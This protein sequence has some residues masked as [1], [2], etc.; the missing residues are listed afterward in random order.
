MAN[1]S[2]QELSAALCH[3]DKR[4]IELLL[5]RAE[6]VQP[7]SHL[8]DLGIS[9]L[10]ETF[11]R[12][13]RHRYYTVSAYHSLVSQEKLDASS[14]RLA[15]VDFG[16]S[17]G[18][19]P[20][21]PK[22]FYGDTKALIKH[23]DAGREELTKKSKAKKTPRNPV[24]P[25]GSVK[26]GRR[27]KSQD[28]EDGTPVQAETSRRQTKKRKR[29]AK[30]DQEAD[31][32]TASAGPST[33]R[34]KTTRIDSGDAEGS[35]QG[36]PTPAICDTLCSPSAVQLFPRNEGVHRKLGPKIRT[37]NRHSQLEW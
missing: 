5:T 27:K 15:E 13:R 10:M 31:A 28:D 19:M 37:L 32:D 12:E 35:V 23:Q 3:F 21:D 20:V 17:C 33:K 11:G 16:D 6:K 34:R 22:S 1:A 30:E 2:F 8:S 14:A 18:F 26:L 24:L 25:D 7:P 4:T 36:N 29:N 9:G